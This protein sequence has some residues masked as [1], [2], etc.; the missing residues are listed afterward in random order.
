MKIKLNEIFGKL[1][2]T[3]G[4]TFIVV[5]LIAGILCLAVSVFDGENQKQEQNTAETETSSL[6]SYSAEEE[7]RVTA[8][9][10]AIDGVKGARVM[11]NFESGSEYVYDSGN[12][13]RSTP[14]LLEE[15]P[16]KISGVAVV[17]VG[18]DNPGIQK[19]I[20]D[21]ICSL[22]G[23]SSSRVSVTGSS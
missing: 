17:C 16:P 11:I 14:L 19:K 3:K 5:G 2:E 6:A 9:L 15:Y 12:Y 8:L 7:Q 1:K 21:L 23:I 20:I 13:S 22:Y 18:G 4:V 10:N